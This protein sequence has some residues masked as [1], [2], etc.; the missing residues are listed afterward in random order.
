M[1]AVGV[2]WVASP[3]PE[4]RRLRE[5]LGVGLLAKDP[6]DW[7][8]QLKLLTGD[9]A[10]RADMSAKGRAAAADWTIEGNAWRWWEAWD[11]AVTA[12][13]SGRADPPASYAF[14]R[15]RNGRGRHGQRRR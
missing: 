8:R 4:Y 12:Q 9:D 13:R 2:P 10:L 5:Q 14:P 7:Y 11:A 3:R 15:K 6:G 1:A